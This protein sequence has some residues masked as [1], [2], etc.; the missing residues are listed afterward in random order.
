VVKDPGTLNVFNNSSCTR[1]SSSTNKWE[2][3]TGGGPVPAS[4]CLNGKPPDRPSVS[5][6]ELPWRRGTL[7]AA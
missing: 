3:E 2:S 4:G 6:M 1:G 5:T 7:G